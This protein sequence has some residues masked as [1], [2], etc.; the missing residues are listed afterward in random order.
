MERLVIALLVEG[1]PHDDI[2][3]QG[4]FE[5]PWHLGA[6]RHLV[7][8]SRR[9]HEAGAD[10][11]QLAHQRLEEA[12]LAR[13]DLPDDRDELALWYGDIEVP[14]RRRLAL[15]EGEGA[16]RPQSRWRRRAGQ[17]G[18]RLADDALRPLRLRE[19][20]ADAP[21]AVRCLGALTDA[22]LHQAQGSEQRHHQPLHDDDLVCR[23]L[24]LR[25]ENHVQGNQHREPRRRVQQAEDDA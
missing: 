3:L 8:A 9:L 21:E 20:H 14:E 19:E 4:A 18:R 6:V 23:N 15:S 17:G 16:L 2:V 5:D 24:S 13:R 12:A 1:G 22:Q 25:A 11:V 7:R 10:G